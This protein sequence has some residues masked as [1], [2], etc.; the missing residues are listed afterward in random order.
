VPSLGVIANRSSTQFPKV[1][2]II[3]ENPRNP[4]ES[5]DKK[6]FINLRESAEICG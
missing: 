6:G 3:S 4:R 1:K 2:K 5:A